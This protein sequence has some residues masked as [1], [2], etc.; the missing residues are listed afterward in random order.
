MVVIAF[1]FQVAEILFLI[2]GNMKIGGQ[3]FLRFAVGMAIF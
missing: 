2:G 3:K 1:L